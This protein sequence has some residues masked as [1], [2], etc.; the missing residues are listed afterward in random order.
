M[1]PPMDADTRRYDEITER[2]I[3]CAFKVANILGPGFLEKVYENALAYE[4]RSAGLYVEQQKA[5]QVRYAGIVV[6]EY[7][8]DLLGHDC[9]LV[10]LKAA[11]ALDDVHTARCLNYL[12]ACGLRVCLLLNFGSPKLL[13]RRIVHEFPDRRSSASIGGSK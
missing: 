10:E 7:V 8:A 13:I 6:G 2:I 11:K 4:L 3:G 5:V 12:K 1:Q 9:I